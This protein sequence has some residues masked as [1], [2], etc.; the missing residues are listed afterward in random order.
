[1]DG[2]GLERES[3]ILY[4]D[5]ASASE[6]MKHAGKHRRTKQLNISDLKIREYVKKRGV[7]IEPVSSK[8]NVADLLTKPL[9]L[10]DFQRHREKIGVHPTKRKADEGHAQ[11]APPR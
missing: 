11:S 4:C 2:L 7:K 5:S 8:A 1:V 6:L 9:P 3:R 10:E